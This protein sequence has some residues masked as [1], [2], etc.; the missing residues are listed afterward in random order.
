MCGILV[1]ISPS[2]EIKVSP[3]CGKRIRS[4]REMAYKQSK[5]QRHRGP[6]HT[7]IVSIP[8]HGVIF[9]QERLAVLLPE[10]GD[11]PL[12]SPDDSII[13]AANGEIY[14]YLELSAKIAKQNGKYEP[15]SD[16]D[17]I[18]AMYEQFG[19]ELVQHI[20]GMFSF[21]LYDKNAKRLIVSRD[22]VGIIPLYKGVDD[23][24]NLWFSSEVKCLVDVCDTVEDF[25]PGTLLTVEN[26]KISQSKYYQPAW[27]SEIPTRKADLTLLR[28]QLVNAVRSHLQSDAPFG[29]LLSGGVDSSLIAS[30]ATQI[31]RERDPNYRLKTYSVGLENAP[32]FKYSRMVADYIDSDH[33]EIIFKIED[34][35]DYIRDTIYH[36]ESY[37]ITTVRCSIPMILMTRFIKSEG[38]KMILSGEGADEIFGGYLYFH[39]APN[40]HEF[41][42]ELVNRVL[43]LHK[44]DCLRAN[45]ATMSY[46]LELRVPFLDTEF[47]NHAMSIRPEDK[48]TGNKNQFAQEIGHG[49][50]RIE[51]H[52]LRAAFAKDYLPDAVLWRQKEQ[53]SDGVGYSW[54]DSIR[55]YAESQ[56]ND[57]EFALAKEIYP[58]NTPVTKEAFYYRTLYEELF[59]GNSFAKT[60]TKWVPRLDWGCNQDPSGRAQTVHTAAY[61]EI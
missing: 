27:I 40:A 11:Q 15:R 43:S 60:V 34:G 1:V 5:K 59:P 10:T 25:E 33:R 44:F 3:K 31:L 28:Q 21:A 4:I 51:K 16:C 8:E 36:T 61:K 57:K 53:F 32:D 58:I 17:V 26:D 24:G 54:I 23:M 14:N 42:H 41:H 49:V 12:K 37:D 22:P 35:L 39:Q 47:L 29:S 19:T 45:K 13:L 7:G 18:I 38:L 48:M 2:G 55:S 6:D 56:I 9:V 50:A 20:T 46:G 30:I 52:I